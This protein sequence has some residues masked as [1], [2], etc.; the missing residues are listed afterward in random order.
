MAL[1]AEAL[2]AAEIGNT[3]QA[4]QLAMNALALSPGRN[5]KICTALALARAGE[6][7]RAMVLADELNAKLPSDTLVQRYWLPTIRG[8]IELARHNPSQ[9]LEMLQSASYE[10]GNHG[11]LAD[12]LYSVYFRG[13]AYL[14]AHQGKEAG[15]EFQRLLDHRSIVLDSPLVALSYLGLARAHSMQGQTAAAQLA[16]Q[17]FFAIWKDADTDLPILKQAQADYAKLQRH[18]RAAVTAH[19]KKPM[20]SSVELPVRGGV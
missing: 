14:S 16:Y 18:S 7:A 20:I 4:K 13:E 1:D 15:L 6:P 17:D 19:T 9:A 5:A 8:A 3:A 12:N 2:R 10:F 11:G